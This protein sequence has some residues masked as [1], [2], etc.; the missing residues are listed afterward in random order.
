[1]LLDKVLRVLL[2]TLTDI[3]SILLGDHDQ[4]AEGGLGP[5]FDALLVEK[6]LQGWLAGPLVIEA[7]VEVAH[8]FSRYLDDGG[9][10]QRT[11]KGEGN[12]NGFAFEDVPLIGTMSLL[13]S[14]FQTYLR[15]A[16]GPCAAAGCR[17]RPSRHAACRHV[18]RVAFLLADCIS[19]SH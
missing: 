1:M 3:G 11:A 8:D 17:A 2:V 7:E 15:D 18:L 9:W 14:A 12:S 10:W 4:V 5:V 19:Q 6:G 13:S 16:S